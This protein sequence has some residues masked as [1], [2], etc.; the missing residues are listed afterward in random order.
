MQIGSSY[1]SAAVKAQYA[2]PKGLDIRMTFHE[3]YSVNRQGYGEWLVSHYDIRGGMTVLEVGCGTGSI[4][5]GHEN[6]ISGCG[7][8][9][10]A[11]LSEGM[12]ETA[13]KNLGRLDNIEYRKADIQSLPF[14]DESFDVVIANAMLYHVPDIGTGLKE[15]RRVLKKGGSFYCS[16]FGEHNFTDTLAE[17]FRL[18]GEDFKPNHNFTMQNGKEILGRSFE[19]IAPLFYEDS[20]HITETEDL[21]EYLRSLASFKAVIDLPVQKIRD[22]LKEHAADG[23]IDLPKEYGMFICA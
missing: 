11:D 16:T 7:K 20:L 19:K 4:W 23:A 12:L 15:V 18:S 17:W 14:A 2:V 5:K 1:D 3:K 22:I 13:E 10:L 6:I 9:I 21:V 8:L